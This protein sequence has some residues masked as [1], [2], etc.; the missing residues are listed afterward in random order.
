MISAIQSQLSNPAQAT[1]MKKTNSVS[2]QKNVSKAD[3]FSK[4]NSQEVSFK[5][6]QGAGSV[7]G[8]VGGLLAAAGA[9]ALAPVLAPAAVII[10]AAA[11]IGGGGAGNSIGAKLDK[12]DEK[13]SK[14]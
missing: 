8:F 4:Q 14:Q 13:S 10:G 5:S 9:V 2:A 7:V 3:S 11:A 6:K 1:K 12:A